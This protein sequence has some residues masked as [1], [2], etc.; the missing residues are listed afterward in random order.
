M[1]LAIALL[2]TECGR[3][4]DARQAF[5]VGYGIYPGHRFDQTFVVHGATL[6]HAAVD[7][8][9]REA[10][11]LLL[12]S[13]SPFRGQLAQ[14]RPLST[15]GPVDLATARLLLLLDRPGE[16]ADHLMTSVEMCERGGLRP[17]LAQS[18][19][20]QGEAAM[21]LGDRDGARALLTDA[22]GQSTAGGFG[23][24]ERRAA[25]RLADLE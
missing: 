20:V 16:A 19:L 9:D 22:R 4:D 18:R 1:V 7:L 11:P 3:L 6:A 23:T 12:E 10:A 21:A 14:W 17:F 24:T 2:L 5:D 13:L 25:A 8:G 15:V